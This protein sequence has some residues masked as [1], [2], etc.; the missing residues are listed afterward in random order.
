MGTLKLWGAIEGPYGGYHSLDSYGT[1]VLFAGGVGITHQLLYIRHLLAGHNAHTATARKILLVWSIQSI[2]MLE[3]I[4]PWVDEI[5]SMPNCQ[6]V[7]RFRIHVSKI[8]SSEALPMGLDIRVGRCDPQEIVDQEV[9]DQVG[10]MVVTVCGP[11]AYGDAIRA[12]VRKRVGLRS[13]DFIE[14]AFSY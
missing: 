11:G 1:I 2:T 12:A 5:I 10:A 13:I 4:R 3:W 8:I 7:V 9:I 14:E 6:E